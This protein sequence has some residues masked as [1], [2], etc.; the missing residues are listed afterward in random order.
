MRGL[1]LNFVSTHQ[2]ENPRGFS[3]VGENKQLLIAIVGHSY[4]FLL[5]FVVVFSSLMSFISFTK[6]FF[7]LSTTTNSLSKISLNV[8]L[9]L[10]VSLKSLKSGHS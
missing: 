8:F 10:S 7:S 3:E 6:D 1:A 9:N 4:F 2:T 5:F